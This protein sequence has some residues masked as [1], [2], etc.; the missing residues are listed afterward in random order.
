MTT[1]SNQPVYTLAAQA[2]WREILRHRWSG[3]LDRALVLRD[4]IGGYHVLGSR[5]RYA[6]PYGET[7]APEAVAHASAAPRLFGGYDSAFHV[8]LH[9]QS[10]TRS[11]AL[12]TVYGTESVDVRVLWWVHDPVEVV[13]SRTAHG[14]DAVRKDLDRRLRHLEDAHAAE[15]QTVGAPEI[16]HE[17]AA[18]QELD[19]FGLTYRVTDI[20]GQESEGELRLGQPGGA[21]L[22]YSW[23]ANR[24]EEFQ[25]CE[26]AVRNGPVSL[27]ALWLLRHPDQVS[28]V[29]DWSVNHRSL[30]K[31]ETNW[32]D[33][34]AG[35]L[36][37]LTEQERKELSGL[38]RDRLAG[39]GRRVPG[40]S[41]P[42]DE[43]WDGPQ[44]APADKSA[45]RHGVNGRWRGS[46]KEW[47]A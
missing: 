2:P 15:G 20:C 29:L 11:V 44:G 1:D 13:R 30:L 19:G 22:P 37:Q 6:A 46:A 4:R 16:M 9:E 3:R 27:A 45:G 17:L 40:P 43:S 24:R 36:G 42:Q 5:K 47:S 35:L 41:A 32:Q 31:E 26:Q 7:A 38:L 23:T 8:Q 33:E 28:Q 18:P 39:L 10:G 21:G 25:F 34:V 14:W 12:P